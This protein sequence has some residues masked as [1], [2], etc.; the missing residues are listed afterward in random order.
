[1]GAQAEAAR[2]AG[3]AAERIDANRIARRELQGLLGE[4]PTPWFGITLAQSE[5]T[6]AQPEAVE[7]IAAGA[8]LVRVPGP[9]GRELSARAQGRSEACRPR[10]ARSMGFDVDA[11][12]ARRGSAPYGRP[13]L[14]GIPAGSQRGLAE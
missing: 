5:L 1:A 13:S 14:E 9:A 11:V 8:D 10:R 2:L 3:A 6:H 12:R 4:S 7:A